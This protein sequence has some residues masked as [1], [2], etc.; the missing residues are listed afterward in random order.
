[1]FPWLIYGSSASEAWFGRVAIGSGKGHGTRERVAS[2]GYWVAPDSEGLT[3]RSGAVDIHTAGRITGVDI[4]SCKLYFN[5]SC[6]NFGD[7]GSYRRYGYFTVCFGR[8]YLSMPRYTLLAD[9]PSHGKRM[10][11][12]IWLYAHVCACYI[13]LPQRE[14]SMVQ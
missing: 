11:I 10:C 5:I 4:C 3:G 13:R 12:Y 1:M 9:N 8:N 6:G 7:K 14:L 2:V